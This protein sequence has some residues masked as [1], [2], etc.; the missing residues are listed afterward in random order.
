MLGKAAKFL[1]FKSYIS[2]ISAESI[3]F[4]SHTEEIT[5]SELRRDGQLSSDL[6]D[7]MLIFAVEFRRCIQRNSY[8]LLP[9]TRGI[10]LQGSKKRPHW[11]GISASFAPF[12][13]N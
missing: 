13:F 5:V 6:S 3:L 11:C 4:I 2:Y 10:F 7:I 9:F 1:F 12:I 8:I